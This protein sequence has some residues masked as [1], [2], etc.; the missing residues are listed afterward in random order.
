MNL[1]ER[2]TRLINQLKSI[3]DEKV[4]G[5][6]ENVL[7]EYSAVYQTFSV[8][9]EHK[10]ILDERLSKLNGGSTQLLDWEEVKTKFT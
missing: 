10:A 3:K 7:N 4:L 1:E 9:V 6:I 8:S 2:R 5:K